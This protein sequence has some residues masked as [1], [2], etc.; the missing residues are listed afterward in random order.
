M[1]Y[2]VICQNFTTLLRAGAFDILGAEL[3]HMS[4]YKWHKIEAVAKKL[5]IIGYISAGARKYQQSPILPSF[6]LSDAQEEKYSIDNAFMFNRF[7]EKRYERICDDE[8][9]DISPSAETTQLLQLIISV[10]DDIIASRLPLNGI[11]ALGRML[12][13]DGDKVDYIKLETWLKRLGITQTASLQASMLIEL[14]DFEKDEFP[15][16]NKFYN[17][18]ITHYYNLIEN[19]LDGKASFN[20]VSKLNVAMLETLSYHLGNFTSRITDIEE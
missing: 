5:N 3:M 16:I 6:M 9:H 7:K 15:Y 8:R 20:Y 18:A 17:N 2:P 1:M 14:F 13:N 4:N 11:I 12:R 19:V 10:H